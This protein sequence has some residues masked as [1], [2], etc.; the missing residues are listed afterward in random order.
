MSNL[1][2]CGYPFITKRLHISKIFP[3]LNLVRLYFILLRLVSH[4]LGFSFTTYNKSENINSTRL[5]Y[6]F[7]KCDLLVSLS[8]SSY[9]FIHET[10]GTQNVLTFSEYEHPRV[11]YKR[12]TSTV[13]FKHLRVVS[14]SETQ[15]LTVDS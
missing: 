2:P 13:C 5:G 4:V 9:I 3:F 11:S 12:P 6:S 8:L 10:L 1:K 15:S 14:G 7:G